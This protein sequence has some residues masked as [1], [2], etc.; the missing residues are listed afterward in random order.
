MKNKTWQRLYKMLKPQT[1][2]IAIIT[3]LAILI[4]IGEVVKPYLIKIVIDDYL[5]LNMYQQG[6]M[7]IGRIGAIYI[8]IVLVG[9]ILNFI[10]TTA[11]SMMGENVI[12]SIRNKLYKYVQYANI[13]FHDRTPAGKLF[14][15]IT[16][17]VE[18]ITTLF[19]DVITTFIK[20]ILMIIAFVIMM[21]S[22]NYKLALLALCIVPFVILTSVIITKISNKLQE[23]SKM[24]KT[25]LNTFLAESIYGVKLIKIFNRQ[26]E[27]QKECEKLCTDFWKSRIPLGITEGFLPAIMTI[28]ENLGV[29]IIVWASIN[30]F[31]GESIDVGLIYVFITYTKQIF[32]PINRLVENFETIQEALVS[33]NKI[34]DILEH[35]EYLEN[36]ETGKTLENVKGKIEF[37]NVWFAYEKDNWVL[38]DIS[39]TIEAGQSVALVGKTGSGKTTITNLINR[40]YEIQKGEIL[41]DGVNIKEI[42]LRSLREKIGIILQDPFV[43]ARSIKDNIQL[44]RKFSDEYI[45]ETIELASAEEFIE[46]LP[47]GIEE[48][49]HERG[50]SYSSGQKQLLAFARIFAHNPSIFILDEA[51]A[52]I[53][54][55]TEELI[56]KSVD[57]IS[58]EKTSIFI[59]HRLSTIV[60]VDKIIVLNQGEI[61][62]EGS[63]NKLVSKTDGYYSRLYNAYYNGLV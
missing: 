55:K 43:F 48:I 19:K 58:K 32:E 57:K 10:V 15:R 16:S 1:K 61:I 27:K 56:Q 13:P 34:Y 62:E 42:N 60:N 38:K 63:H 36:F 51:T 54:T 24:V 6:I 45:M 50:N 22:L 5:E 59:A 40:F 9:N 44:N 26:Y 11:T 25:K 17:D 28:L 20:D 53:D 41:L 14:V 18:D 33:I 35:K 30:H 52:N 49:S 46:S 31:V 29:S 2:S 23:Y 12:Y 39:F 3:V 37:K 7:T 21:L 8:A 4:N 47:N